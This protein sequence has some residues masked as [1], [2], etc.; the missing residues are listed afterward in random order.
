MLTLVC[1][2]GV[3]IALRNYS[4]S[5]NRAPLLL[6][7]LRAFKVEHALSCLLCP[8]RIQY[9]ARPCHSSCRLLHAHQVLFRVRSMYINAHVER[10]LI[11]IARLT[12]GTLPVFIHSLPFS[13]HAAISTRR[14]R[15]LLLLCL[16]LALSL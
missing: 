11:V 4:R 10:A 12:H 6:C 9:S 16:C 15:L 5:V 2:V 3:V 13:S 1:M 7:A 8:G 14:V